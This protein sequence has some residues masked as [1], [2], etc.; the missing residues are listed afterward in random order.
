MPEVGDGGTGLASERC[1]YAIVWCLRPIHIPRVD[2]QY[3]NG[4]RVLLW[5]SYYSCGFTGGGRPAALPRHRHH[6]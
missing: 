4:P 6:A 1:C 3:V 5:H 2:V